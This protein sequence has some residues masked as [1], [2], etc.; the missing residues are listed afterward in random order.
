MYLN[1]KLTSKNFYNGVIENKQLNSSFFNTR[2]YKTLPPLKRR[3]LSATYTFG[4]Q[5][6]KVMPEN[7]P[8]GKYH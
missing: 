8:A 1:F 5:D 6:G 4:C 2:I 7:F 3:I